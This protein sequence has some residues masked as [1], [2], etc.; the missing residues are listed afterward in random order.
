MQRSD[1]KIYTEADFTHLPEDERPRKLPFPYPRANGSYDYG[2]VGGAKW[3]D[4]HEQK[5]CSSIG[6]EDRDEE[7]MIEAILTGRRS[8]EP[9]TICNVPHFNMNYVPSPQT[10]MM[11]ERNI[12][13]HCSFWE[14]KVSKPLP[15]IIGGNGY[16]PGNRTTGQFRGMGGRRFDIEFIDGPHKGKR[17]T[18]F[19][20]WSGGKAPKAWQDRYKDN[21]I[22]LNG[23]ER[24]ELDNPHTA[25]AWDSSSHDNPPYPLPASIG[26]GV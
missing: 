9:C 25:V 7:K 2:W 19:D 14:E 21:A 20:L 5:Y 6:P 18:T 13:F 23:A 26:L 3:Y 17:I 24:A 1:V 16:S 10:T 4:A 11:K 22:F 15:V 8:S 12:C